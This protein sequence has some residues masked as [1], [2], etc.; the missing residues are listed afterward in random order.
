MNKL[1]ENFSLEEFNCKDG[2]EVPEHLI[3]NIKEL[4]KNLQ[5]LRDELKCAIHINSGFRT[6]EYNLK[7]GGVKSSQH[8]LGK[9]A[10]ITARNYS[11]EEVANKI[12]GLISEGKMQDGGLGRYKGF[13]H[14]DVRGNHAR[15][16]G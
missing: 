5:I 14:Y 1:T 7:I 11:P 4:A 9:A 3:P 16:E 6:P 12:E 15:W 2:N 13:T 8:L 10:D